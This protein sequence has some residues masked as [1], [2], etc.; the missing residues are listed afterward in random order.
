[1]LKYETEREEDSRIIV[2]TSMTLIVKAEMTVSQQLHCL[3]F[4]LFQFQ[5]L[6]KIL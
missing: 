6:L 4:N 1:M 3:C 2:T 5:N